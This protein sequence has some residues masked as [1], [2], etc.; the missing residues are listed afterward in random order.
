[1]LFR[2]KKKSFIFVPFL[3]DLK[4]QKIENLQIGA[5]SFHFICAF[6]FCIFS[7]AEHVFCKLV[8]VQN[9]L[10]EL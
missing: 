10:T 5:G 9:L 3:L 1:M 7:G 8:G 6:L 4:E 2:E